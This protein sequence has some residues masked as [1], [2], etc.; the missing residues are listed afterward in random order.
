MLGFTGG[1]W[2]SAMYARIIFFIILVLPADMAFSNPEPSQFHRA[3]TA[4][5]GL[6]IS[7]VVAGE[8]P[9]IILVHGWGSDCRRNWIDSHWVQALQTRRRV[10]CIDVRGHGKSSKPYALEPYGYAALSAD[11]LGVMDALSVQQADYLGYSMGAFMGA[12][13]LGHHADRFTSMILGGIGDETAASAAQGAV[14]GQAL[15]ADDPATI[16]SDYGRAVRQFV[17]ANPDNDLIALAYSAEAMWPEGYPLAVGGP[18]IKTANVPVLIVNGSQDH[19][20]VD[21][22]D[23]FVNQLSDGQHVRLAGKDHLTAVTDPHFKEIA[24]SFL[25]RQN[26]G[27]N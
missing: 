14:I 1:H 8:G 6:M 15:R 4:V 23:H 19:P 26:V 7:Y 21:S 17:A 25:R 10:I 27:Q 12:Y 24:L 18:G 11:V 3:Q 22:A 2:Q 13:L 16:E 20:Y 5:D 9:P